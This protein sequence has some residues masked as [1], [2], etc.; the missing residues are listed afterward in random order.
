MDGNENSKS[1]EEWK[2]IP[3]ITRTFSG[4]QKQKPK[5]RIEDFNALLLAE[6]AL[7]KAGKEKEKHG[8]F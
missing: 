7:V 6:F 3:S 1:T 8:L 2:K 4:K 5:P